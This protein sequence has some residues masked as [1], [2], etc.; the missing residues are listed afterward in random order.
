MLRAVTAIRNHAVCAR[1][2][3][4]TE[5]NRSLSLKRAK[6]AQLL[7]SCSVSVAHSYPSAWGSTA[8]APHGLRAARKPAEVGV[9]ADSIAAVHKAASTVT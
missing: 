5:Q 2:V 4:L 1:W 6:K 8:A 3:G 9:A 7:V